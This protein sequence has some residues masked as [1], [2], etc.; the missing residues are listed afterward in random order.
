MK[1]RDLRPCDWCNKQIAGR[2]PDGRLSIQFYV[3]TLATAILNTRAI[4]EHIS[5]AT[6]LGGS[7]V[8]AEV[9][10]SHP[11]VAEIVED[12][13]GAGG[14][15]EALICFDCWAGLT[16]PPV[17]LAALAE[18]VAERKAAE[19]DA[20][21]EAEKARTAALDPNDPAPEPRRSRRR[22]VTPSPAEE[23]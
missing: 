18:R 19:R 14:R 10:S 16:K 13:P 9:F 17:S 7:H 2:L 11:D 20:A 8:L 4:N 3:V 12:Q 6:M 23:A 5:L 21:V 22:Q 1:L 15:V